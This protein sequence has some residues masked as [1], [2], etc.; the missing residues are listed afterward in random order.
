LES[1]LTILAPASHVVRFEKVRF[2]AT[3]VI[4]SPYNGP[5]SD[6][7]DRAWIDLIQSEYTIIKRSKL[8]LSVIKSDM[9]IAVSG[10]DLQKIGGKSI[11]IPGEKDKYLGGLS[12]YHELHCLV[13]KD[14]LQGGRI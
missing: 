12:V 11:P 4:D 3:L 2:N 1:L 10:S 7:V 6:K 5:P 8:L 9:N 14:T 13:S